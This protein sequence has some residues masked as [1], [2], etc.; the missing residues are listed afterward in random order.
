MDDS[1]RSAAAQ[2][3]MDDEDGQGR[4]R[5]NYNKVRTFTLN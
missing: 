1:R 2:F 3:F 5:P 4:E